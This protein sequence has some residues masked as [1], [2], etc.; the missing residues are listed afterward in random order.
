MLARLDRTGEAF[1][2]PLVPSDHETRDVSVVVTE[3]ETVELFGPSG[4]ADEDRC[5]TAPILGAGAP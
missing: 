2:L 5:R 1:D 4:P 3:K